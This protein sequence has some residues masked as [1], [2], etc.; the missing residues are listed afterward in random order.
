M[1]V[2]F[3]R[4]QSA[5]SAV[6]SVI[7]P[8]NNSV[9]TGR[10]LTLS[11]RITDPGID[12]LTVSSGKSGRAQV[13]PVP[14]GKET[15]CKVLPVNFRANEIEVT[16]S[17]SGKIVDTAKIA[18]SYRSDISNR[19]GPTGAEFTW[20]P[21]HVEEREA[22]CGGC[23]RMNVTAGDL[24]PKTPGDSMCYP[25][26][27]KITD[28]KSVHGPSARW[29][30]LRC[31]EKDSK[32]SR[33]VITN[34]EA[35][36]CFSCHTGE[37]VLWAK[38]KYMHGPAATGKCSICHDPHASPSRYTLKLPVRQLCLSCHENVLNDFKKHSF[39]VFASVAEEHPIRG[40][41]DP[42]NPGEKITCAS[43]HNP[44]ASVTPAMLAY[45]GGSIYN[46][47]NQCHK[48]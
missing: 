38:K 39:K 18:V 36:L 19:S 4:I 13:L 5:D 9:I 40:V 17:R 2:I 11:L 45:E 28:N 48:K 37:K 43:C 26:H 32:P 47:C 30:C 3:S 27:K 14:K 44:H 10:F 34:T 35:D 25:C 22:A 1:I 15:F 31:H 23:H 7:Q 20:K 24:L 33:F 46:F 21:F 29:E 16:A 12:T 42:K 6:M 41:R 8:R